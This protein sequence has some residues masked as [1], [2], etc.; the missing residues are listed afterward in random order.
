MRVIAEIRR[1]DLLRLNLHFLPR[2]KGNWIFVG[3]IAVAAVAWAIYSGAGPLTAKKLAIAIFSGLIGG[4]A[5]LLIATTINFLSILASSS[6]KTGVLGRHEF[7]IRSDG[8][9]E[10]TV[11]NEQ[12]SKWSGIAA[13]ED[14]NSFIYVKINGYLFHIIPRRSFATATEYDEFFTALRTGW[15][16]AAA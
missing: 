6:L 2:R 7:E 15:Q 3:A 10:R 8:L 13:V 4:L 11:A 16:S 9:F 1:S 14:V 5:G 12:L